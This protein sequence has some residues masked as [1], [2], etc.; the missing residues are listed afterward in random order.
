M[1]S[2][3]HIK[4]ARNKNFFHNKNKLNIYL[5]SE[6]GL[7]LI[8]DKLLQRALQHRQKE[9]QQQ[10]NHDCTRRSCRLFHL[11]CDSMPALPQPSKHPHYRS[12][13]PG[14]DAHASQ[15]GR[16]NGQHADTVRSMLL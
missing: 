9:R 8:I 6:R 12:R 4:C 16:R 15:R 7:T 3:K 1:A 5:L 10:L 2:V 14:H 11:S 13:S